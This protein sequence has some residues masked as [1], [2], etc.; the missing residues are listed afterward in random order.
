MSDPEVVLPSSYREQPACWS[1]QHSSPIRYDGDI[2]CMLE[3]KGSPD[4][5]KEAALWE[6]EHGVSPNGICDKHC[7]INRYRLTL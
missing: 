1:C 5:W 3:Y 6:K 7:P 4:N 2:A